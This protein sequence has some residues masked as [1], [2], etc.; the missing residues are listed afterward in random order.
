MNIAL[1][2]PC[3]NCENQIS[4]TLKDIDSILTDDLPI[5][6]VYII[7]NQSQDRTIKVAQDTISMLY[8]STKFKVY[9]NYENVGLGGSHKIAFSLAKKMKISHLMIFHGDHQASAIDIPLL[10]KNSQLNQDSTILGSR[11]TNMQLL[12]GYSLL[13]IIGNLLLN[14]LYSIFT[15]KKITDLGSGLNLFNLADID[16]H[17]VQNFDNGFTFNMDLLLYLIRNKKKISYAPIHWS[18]SDQIS[19]AHALR[20]GNKTLFKLFKWCIH[21]KPTN[22]QHFDSELIT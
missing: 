15:F 18:T 8:Y 6:G 11:F 5:V 20:V 14:V 4:R 12:S 3:Y 13:R 21:I 16:M 22:Q 9:R 7:D 2:I 17:E 10:I 19:N 1:F